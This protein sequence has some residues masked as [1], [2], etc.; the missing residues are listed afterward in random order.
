MSELKTFNLGRVRGDTSAAEALAQQAAA[1][2]LAAQQF[3]EQAAQNGGVASSDSSV[4]NIIALTKAQF[5]DSQQNKA[6]KTLYITYGPSGVIPVVSGTFDYASG[7]YVSPGVHAND[8]DTVTVTATLGGQTYAG[9]AD[10]AAKTFSIALPRG[11]GYTITLSSAIFRDIQITGV[12][13]R[14]RNL[15]LSTPL[16]FTVPKIISVA[17]NGNLSNVQYLENGFK[18][19]GGGTN[20][21]DFYWLNAMASGGFVINY[22]IAG[23]G[24]YPSGFAMDYT[25]DQQY[26][27]SLGGLAGYLRFPNGNN[28]TNGAFPMWNSAFPNADPL[29]VTLIFD[30][31]GQSSG[32]VGK[33]TFYFIINDT[34][35]RLWEWSWNV[36]DVWHNETGSPNFFA[37]ANRVLGFR[38]WDNDFTVTNI[39]YSFGNAAAAAAIAG[40]TWQA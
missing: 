27:V 14:S 12:N 24:P 3:A 21:T 22:T 30:G 1:S 4:M 16:E 8:A 37:L 7:T 20:R 38:R 35:L 29:N 25:G 13:V 33:G 34:K 18:I 10:A 2:A 5:E 17:G 9:Q 11:K 31:V 6:A 19:V 39:Q 15:A 32:N 28:T 26:T 40:K 23:S 36:G